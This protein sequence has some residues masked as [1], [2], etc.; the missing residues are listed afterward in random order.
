MIISNSDVVQGKC[1]TTPGAN[2]NFWPGSHRQARETGSPKI[3]HSARS[4][5]CNIKLASLPGGIFLPC[6]TQQRW[7]SWSPLGSLPFPMASPWR[8][9]L[10]KSEWRD[11]VVSFFCP[12]TFNILWR[13]NKEKASDQ[14]EGLGGAWLKHCSFTRF[15][16]ADAD[17]CVDGIHSYI[18]FTWCSS[19][20]YTICWSLGDTPGRR[21][22]WIGDMLCQTQ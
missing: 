20:L 13:Q 10:A 15:G 14:A 3:W 19:T 21:V 7:S 1:A 2:E 9:R 17:W 5:H 12:K 18:I 22:S 4:I 6:S 8:W 11:P 16:D